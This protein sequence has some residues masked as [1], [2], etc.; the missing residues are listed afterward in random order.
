MGV[1]SVEPDVPRRKAVSTMQIGGGISEALGSVLCMQNAS[2]S[3]PEQPLV[4][5][6]TRGNIGFPVVAKEMRR[7]AGP[8]G[9]AARHDVLITADVDVSSEEGRHYAAWVAY[10]TA[11]KKKGGKG[12][13]DGDKENATIRLGDIVRL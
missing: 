5:V 2:L 4:L 11:E 10:R 1:F 8:R 9:G 12:K 7:L 6:S 13:E 3:K